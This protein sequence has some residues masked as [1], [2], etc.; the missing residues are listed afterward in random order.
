MKLAAI[1]DEFSR[2]APPHLAW[3]DDPIGLHVGRTG[4]D[5]IDSLLV[6]LDVI[7]PVVNEAAQTGAQLIFAHHPLIYR[8]LRQ[9]TDATSAQKT[10]RELIRRDIA[11]F[12][13]HTN[14]DSSETGVCAT[15]ATMIGLEDVQPLQRSETNACK[16]V[17]YVPHEAIDRVYSAMCEAGAGR[18]G[19]YRD[20]T[21]RVAGTG[22]F[23]A[24][25]NANP[26]I[27][28]PGEHSEV[29]EFRLEATAPAGSIERILAAVRAAH[30]YEMPAI[31]VYPLAGMNGE[32]GLGRIGSLPEPL[33][34]AELARKTKAALDARTVRLA[35]DIEKQCSVIAV[36]GGAGGACLDDAIRARCDAF[37]VGELGYHEAIEATERGMGVIAAGHGDSERIIVPRV[38]EL[39]AERLDGV[40]VTASAIRTSP[41]RQWLG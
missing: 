39:L 7:P 21:F 33:T 1:I 17:V 27:G 5:D 38:A 18:F 26:A 29:D 2:L 8:P 37:V 32:L 24:S 22:T 31:D 9:L 15:L 23:T 4:G 40:K 19:E 6:A 13:A 41:W 16:V 3:P 14:L 34:L 20:C 35:G 11:L 10:V 12:V 25:E 36:C 28:R 30:P